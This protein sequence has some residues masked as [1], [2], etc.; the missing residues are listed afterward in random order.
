[1][2]RGEN[3]AVW[4]LC[5]NR[6]TAPPTTVVVVDQGEEDDGAPLKD[7]DKRLSVM[8]PLAVPL[9]IISKHKRGWRNIEIKGMANVTVWVGYMVS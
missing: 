9:V 5:P 2:G 8:V 6:R 3:S 1:M 4:P 7:L